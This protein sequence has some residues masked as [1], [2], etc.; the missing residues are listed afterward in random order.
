MKV[1]R[2][3]HAPIGKLPFVTSRLEHIY[4]DLI[5][6]LPLSNGFSSALTWVYRYTRWPEVLPVNNIEAATVALAL[7]EGWIARFG[8][9]LH[10]TTAQ[11]RQLESNLF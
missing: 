2:H 11:E 6:P 9:P 10:I 4:I 3:T 5:G 7:F 8:V 1:S